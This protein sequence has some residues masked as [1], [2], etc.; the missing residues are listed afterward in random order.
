MLLV[1]KGYTIRSN[2]KIS[3]WLRKQTLKFL[4]KKVNKA[5]ERAL[6]YIF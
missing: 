1:W 4:G 5:N 2:T 3:L 6:L